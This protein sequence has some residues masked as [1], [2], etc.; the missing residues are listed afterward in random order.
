MLQA[1]QAPEFWAQFEKENDPRDAFRE[2]IRRE[3]AAFAHDL[4]IMPIPVKLQG[5]RYGVQSFIPDELAQTIFEGESEYHLWLL[6]SKGIFST[7]RGP[8]S[9]DAQDLKETLCANECV[10]RESARKLMGGVQLSTIGGWLRQLKDKF[11][12]RIE[13]SRTAKERTW[14]IQPLAQ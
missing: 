4:E 13:K 5:R 14:I 11:P 9:G 6:I 1:R 2:A 10:V 12:N 8:W 3:L 7:E